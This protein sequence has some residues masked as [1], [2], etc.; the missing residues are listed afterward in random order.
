MKSAFKHEA[1]TTP[2][3]ELEFPD[4]AEQVQQVWNH[5]VSDMINK[6][7]DEKD[8]LE[9]YLNNIDDDECDTEENNAY[10]ERYYVMLS[11]LLLHTIKSIYIHN[12]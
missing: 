11:C 5:C 12:E 4:I 10:V 9:K 8:Y 6:A 2:D 1:K 3:N 7:M